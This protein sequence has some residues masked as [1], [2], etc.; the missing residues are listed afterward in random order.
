[1]PFDLSLAELARHID[2]TPEQLHEWCK[3]GLIGTPAHPDRFTHIDVDDHHRCRIVRAIAGPR[4]Q[5]DELVVART[6]EVAR[7]NVHG[8]APP[9]ERREDR[10]RKPTEPIG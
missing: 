5:D 3:H 10:L 8:K 9:N 7:R 4:T 6:V 1:M 2:A